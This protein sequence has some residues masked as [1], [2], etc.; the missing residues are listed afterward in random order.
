MRKRSPTVLQKRSGCGK[1]IGERIKF[2]SFAYT[3]WECFAGKAA[4]GF[5][6]DNAG[7]WNKTGGDQNVPSCF[8]AEKEKNCR[9]ARLRDGTA[10]RD[11]GFR[12]AYLRRRAGLRSRSHERGTNAVRRHLLRAFGYEKNLGGGLPMP[13]WFT[14]TRRRRLPPRS[15]AII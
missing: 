11:A 10:P 4:D 7:L 1:I 8:G 6:K 3:F 13:C 9:N 12:F 5:E 15:L 2:P 14:A